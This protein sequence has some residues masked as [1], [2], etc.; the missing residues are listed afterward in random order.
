M[1]FQ[2]LFPVY[3]MINEIN[4]THGPFQLQKR[5]GL[6]T[7]EAWIK[8]ENKT[9]SVTFQTSISISLKTNKQ[10]FVN[11]KT[12]YHLFQENQEET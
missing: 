1:T 4:F 3:Q 2:I 12:F 11:R 5:I 9:S 6:N 10:K 7:D 8:G